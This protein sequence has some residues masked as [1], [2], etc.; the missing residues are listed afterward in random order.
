MPFARTNPHRFTTTNANKATID[1]ELNIQT[2]WVNV[3]DQRIDDVESQGIAGATDP[4]NI[5]KLPT[6]D[7]ENINWIKLDLSYFQLK[8]LT[9]E[10]FQD[11]SINQ[12]VLGN[13]CVGTPQLIDL[14]VTFA[15]I[16][17]GNIG[18]AKMVNNSTMLVKLRSTGHSC[19]IIGDDAN[20]TY[21]ELP[22]A[23]NWNIATRIP[24]DTKPS[25]QPF[26]NFWNAQTD[27]TLRGIKLL[28]LSVGLT[29]IDSG[30]QSAGILGSGDG[31][32]A[33]A[34]ILSQNNAYG[35][36]SGGGGNPIA[37]RAI[38]NVLNNA[39]RNETKGTLLEDGRYCRKWLCTKITEPGIDH[40][41]GNRV[42]SGSV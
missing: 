3:L 14:S 13:I 20:Y 7:G 36:V 26:L 18:N 39:V 8:S 33:V 38:P 32:N 42:L 10:V 31:T 40:A 34:L 30:S 35:I 23:P 6:T 1:D 12:R 4:R 21:T 17:D 16:A 25:M 22:V 2:G 15:K 27:N 11:D 37:F 9:G 28:N 24:N 5:G 41:N 29:K 19:F